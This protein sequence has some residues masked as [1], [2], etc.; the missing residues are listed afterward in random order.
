M[1][2]KHLRIKLAMQAVW[3]I[4]GV[5]PIASGGVFCFV[6]LTVCLLSPHPPTNRFPQNV[7]RPGK[8]LLVCGAGSV[9]IAPP[10]VIWLTLISRDVLLKSFSRVAAGH[11]LMDDIYPLE[12]T[13]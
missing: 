10:H 12:F 9:I 2:L 11:I 13:H 8:R 3:N 5:E 1:I 7:M 6:F 4:L